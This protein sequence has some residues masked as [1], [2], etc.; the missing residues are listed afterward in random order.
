MCHLVVCGPEV[1]KWRCS[2]VVP[3]LYHTCVLS[4]FH[5]MQ[6]SLTSIT[7]EL[8]NLPSLRRL[9]LK[10]SSGIIGP[11]ADADPNT[12]SGLCTVVQV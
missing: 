5:M 12:S 11:L 2:N 4:L 8:A 6:A 10:H 3:V 1:L 7:S 9:E